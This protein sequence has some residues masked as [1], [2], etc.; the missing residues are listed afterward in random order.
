MMVSVILISIVIYF[1]T[2]L[3]FYL[4]KRYLYLC[5]QPVIIFR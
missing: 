1:F 4:S 2:F 5:L 3:L